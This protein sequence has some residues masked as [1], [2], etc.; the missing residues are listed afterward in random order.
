MVESLLTTQ[1]R[2]PIIRRKHH[3]CAAKSNFIGYLEQIRLFVRHGSFGNGHGFHI[4]VANSKSKCVPVPERRR[5]MIHT[6]AVHGHVATEFQHSKTFFVIVNHLWFEQVGEYRG[7]KN[8]VDG[9]IANW[10]NVV[11]FHFP[12]HVV[13]FSDVV[14]PM[15]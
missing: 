15:K 6:K 9:L 4:A 3:L 7:R 11:I 12:G 8:E 10:Q 5:R 2:L 1:Q 14:G 13:G